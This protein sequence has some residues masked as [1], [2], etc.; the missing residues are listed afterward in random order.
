[1]SATIAESALAPTSESIVEVDDLRVW[2]PVRDGLLRRRVGYLRAVD[3]VSFTIGRGETLGLVGESGCGK[4]TTGRAIL[5]L[6]PATGGSVTFDGRDVLALG[7]E[8]MRKLR[9][10]M[11]IVFQDPY[12]SL[13]PRFTIGASIAEGVRAQKLAKAGQLDG[14]VKDL[15]DAV[16]LDGEMRRRYPHELSG[17]Q[18]Q[19]VVIARALATRPDFIVCDEAVSALDVSVRAQVLNLL[20]DLQEQFGLT[21]LFIAHDLSVV[22]HVSDRVAVMY[23][24]KIVEVAGADELYT[25]PLHPY[26]RA[27]LTA[28]PNPDP[29]HAGGRAPLAG[30]V[31]SPLD[32]PTGCRFRTRCPLA[33]GRCAVEEPLLGPPGS[34]HQVACHVTG[35]AVDE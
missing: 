11:Q 15:L 8:E 34:T 26:T 20:Q 25:A 3:D 5:R 7:S 6:Q 4:T 12:S 22:Q 9:A 27:L 29:R 1:M 30:E 21:Y 16:G 17:G 18:R 13:D 23:L 28:I 2:F 33:I 35:E 24:G 19:R 10:R 14:I 31:P 32:I